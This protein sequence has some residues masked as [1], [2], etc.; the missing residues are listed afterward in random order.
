[1]DEREWLDAIDPRPML[2]ALPSNV[3]DRV[4]RLFAVACCRRIF[5]LL[6]DELGAQAIKNAEAC[7]DGLIT[8]HELFAILENRD[9]RFNYELDEAIAKQKQVS[10][11]T[12]SAAMFAASLIMGFLDTKQTVNITDWAANAVALEKIGNAIDEF[13]YDDQEAT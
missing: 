8:I 2:Q 5:H 10:R 1:M 4:L 11:E 6:D 9:F 3:S 13:E 7:A 12:I